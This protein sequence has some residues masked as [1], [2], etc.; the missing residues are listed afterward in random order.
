MTESLSAI[1]PLA[2]CRDYD[3]LIV[4]LRQRCI[5]LG[6]SMEA[7]DRVAGL[8]D[9]Y[10][11]KALGSSRS[12]GRTSLGPLLG[13]LGLKLA[14]LPDND[15]LARVRHRLIPRQTVGGKR[16][17]AAPGAD[18]PRKRARELAAAL[19]RLRKRR[20]VSSPAP[21]STPQSMV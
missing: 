16:M 14:V 17:K 8:P 5:E 15:A 18:A 10:V 12:L 13:A 11:T 2:I 1:E 19:K 20:K 7:I 4:A 6:T 9:R 3:G 21:I